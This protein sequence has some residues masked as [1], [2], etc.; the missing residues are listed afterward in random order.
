MNRTERLI[1]RADR[2]AT[3]LQEHPKDYQAVIASLKVKSDLIEHKRY[4]EVIR[5]QK[6]I[7]EVR[8]Q[9]KEIHNGKKRV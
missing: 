4:L 1:D 9:R 7:A 6:R 8:R 3:H 2:L 5:R